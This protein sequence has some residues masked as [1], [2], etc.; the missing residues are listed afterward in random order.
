MFWITLRELQLDLTIIPQIFKTLL[1][2]AVIAS[3]LQM[4]P[5]KEVQDPAITAW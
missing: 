2:V 3:A 5:K 4:P 1:D